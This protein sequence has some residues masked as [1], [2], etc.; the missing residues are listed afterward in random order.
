MLNTSPVISFIATASADAALN[1]YQSILG[2]FLV[3]DS[4]FALVF[5][6][7]GT[8]LRIQKVRS[9][10]PAAHTALGW[11]VTDIDEMV[12]A[13]SAKGVVFQR[14]P[15]LP[16]DEKAIWRT[17]D[18]ASVAWFL[19]PDGNVLSLTQMPKPHT[20]TSSG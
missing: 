11:T 7:F 16:Q 17:P 15:G 12:T 13:L 5:D 2:L 10:V 14:Y 4:P 9:L 20:A 1:F 8:P 19:D 18:G 6:A 3:E